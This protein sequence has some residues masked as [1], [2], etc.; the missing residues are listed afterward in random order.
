MGI[1]RTIKSEY[2]MY[3][4]TKLKCLVAIERDNCKTIKAYF[5]KNKGKKSLPNDTVP[6]FMFVNDDEFD[7]LKIDFEKP[8]KFEIS[9]LVKA[10]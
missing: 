10:K 8:L 6:G 4:N 1:L 2:E 3:E 5:K 9:S 7:S